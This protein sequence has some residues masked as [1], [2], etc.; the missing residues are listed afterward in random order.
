MKELTWLEI[1][2][3]TKGLKGLREENK[4]NIPIEYINSTRRM[5]QYLIGFY[6]VSGLVLGF[7]IGR[8]L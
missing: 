7:M 2:I 8:T 6:L 5:V 4:W 1:A 3:G